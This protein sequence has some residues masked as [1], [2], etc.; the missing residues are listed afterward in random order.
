MITLFTTV[1]RFKT[2]ELNEKR[3]PLI[4]QSEAGEVSRDLYRPI[5][6]S[7][8]CHVLDKLVG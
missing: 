6:S 1:S 8:L 7:G 4:V 2:K 5:G 3:D